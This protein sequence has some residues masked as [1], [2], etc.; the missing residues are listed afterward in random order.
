MPC[1]D[2]IKGLVPASCIIL[3]GLLGCD[4]GPKLP[5]VV[6]VTGYI[7]LNDEPVAGATVV[8]I[9]AQKSGRSAAGKTDEFGNFSL[10]T[11]FNPQLE[12]DGAEP[13][14]YMIQVTKLE[15][16]SAVP[17]PPPSDPSLS[18]QELM[19][20]QTEYNMERMKSGGPKSLLPERYNNPKTSELKA[21]VIEGMPHLK[22]EL[23]D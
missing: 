16:G 21:S 1:A 17:A 23:T 8:F 11:Y 2:Y 22:L 4:S 15:E 19:K 20:L 9:S 14:E 13:G 10:A 12:L 3:A 18:P 6:P 5:K 7:S